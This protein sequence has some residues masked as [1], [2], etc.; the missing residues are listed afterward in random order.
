MKKMYSEKQF[1]TVCRLPGQCFKKCKQALFLIFCVLISSAGFAQNVFTITWPLTS[2]G[3]ATKTGAGASDIIENSVYVGSTYANPEYNSGLIFDEGNTPTS[4]GV[5]YWTGRGGASYPNSKFT[6]PR[7]QT[8][9]EDYETT[10]MYVEFSIIASESKDLKINQISIPITRVYS[11]TS[12][13]GLHCSIA[14]SLDGFSGNESSVNYILGTSSSAPTAIEAEGTFNYNQD[15]IVPRGKSLAVRFIVWRRNSAN[16]GTS[17]GAIRMKI[18]SNV[19][20]SGTSHEEPLPV[21]LTSFTGKNQ[22]NSVVLNWS[23]VSE[24]DNSHFDILRSAD[25]KLFDKIDF[26]QGRGTSDNINHYSYTDR[27]PYR[28]NN[29]YKLKQVD[30][31]GNSE[32][33]QALVVKA[34]SDAQEMNIYQRENVVFAEVYAA[35]SSSGTLTVTDISGKIISSKKVELTAGK[36]QFNTDLG[37]APQGI[38]LVNSVSE[39]KRIS[40]KFIK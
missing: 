12:P 22:G 11:G 37:V 32:E 40:V 35:V 3:M 5:G 21:S 33:S 10:D 31:N 19:T 14:Y 13:G 29:Y 16:I 7:V 25:G 15:I 24:K 9:Y 23:T 2:D 39:G 34:L 18:G 28:G 6:G 4:T 20:I 1:A 17:S 30:F 26:V 36:N 38:Y 8:N 27:F